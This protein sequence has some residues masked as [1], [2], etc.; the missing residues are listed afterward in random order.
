M[1]R[2]SKLGK[3]YDTDHFCQFL[4]DILDQEMEYSMLVMRT[5]MQRNQDLKDKFHRFF[6]ALL[7]YY[8]SE[9]FKVR[10]EY[11]WR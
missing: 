1:V 10:L 9:V 4:W 2:I 8:L 3:V 5:K 7:V 11:F 6:F